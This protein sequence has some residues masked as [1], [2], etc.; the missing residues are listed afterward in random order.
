MSKAND[1]S[2]VKT[3]YSSDKNLNARIELHKRF[4]TNKYGW[5]K[6]VFDQY[7]L[8]PNYK[9]IEFG[10]GNGATWKDNKDRIP[11]EIEITL[12]DLSEGMLSAC[13][14]GLNG[15]T[16]VKKYEVLDI[17]E[18][19][20]GDN[21]FD[22]VIANHMLYHVP[23]RD[24]AIKEVYRVLKPEGIFYAATNG[25]TGNKQLKNLVEA[26]DNRID[27][28]EFSVVKEFGLEN[29][30]EQLSKYFKDVKMLR[31]VDSFHITEAQPLVNYILSLEGHTNVLD[32][33]TGSRLKE[34]YEYIEGI[35][36]EE[37]SIDIEKSTGIFVARK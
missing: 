17:Q 29:G 26:F 25:L 4:S 10:C 3:Q 2:I 9:V 37:G 36:S 34:F 13:R 12:S 7:E 23:N 8:K 28:K 5:Q 11:S 19:P 15:V 22:V 18:I 6:W 24:K 16:A 35:I 31:Y 1:S 21:S 27:Y 20:Y 33:L 30:G 32:I 14:V